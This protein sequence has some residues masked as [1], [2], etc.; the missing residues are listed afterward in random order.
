MSA[1]QQSY[2]LLI[3][4]F[5]R[6]IVQLAADSLFIPNEADLQITALN[7]KLTNLKNANSNFANAY[8]ILTN[9]RIARDR[10]L[11]DKNIGMCEIALQVK[12]YVLSIFNAKA[13]E[14]RMVSKIAFKKQNA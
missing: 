11:Y 14:Y 8:T 1:S 2:D 6:L 12:N 7:Q 10:A 5:S 3:E 9:T 4:H 13:P